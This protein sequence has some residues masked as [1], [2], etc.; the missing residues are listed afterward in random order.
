VNGDGH[1]DLVVGAYGNDAG[2]A[3]AGR[4]YVFHGGPAADTTADIV[5][6]GLAAGDQFGW[7]VGTAGD[8]RGDGFSDLVAG[9]YWNDAAGTDA[10]AAY[11]YDCD[12][13]FVSYPNGG[14]TFGGDGS[15]QVEWLGA[16]PADLWLSVDNG[17]TYERLVRGM[18]GAEWNGAEVTVPNVNTDQALV[19][20][21]PF[22]PWIS[23]SD[24]SDAV[25]SIEAWTGVGPES[26]ELRFRAPWPNPSSGAVRFGLELA[27]P[28]VVT[29]T[30]LDVAGREVARPIAGERFEAGK[31][32]REWRP[33]N[34]APGVYTVRAA[35]GERKLTR[36]LVWLGGK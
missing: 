24:S 20:V 19:K 21:T 25:F 4:A 15:M 30:V 26:A 13:Y 27:R 34:L 5:L 32:T 10:G 9:A 6:T 18:G 28:S 17:A 12:R 35:V 8:L 31:V 29:V 33:E 2:G 1:A 14:E 3:D 16:E 7:S 22:E 11:V 36:R 23:G